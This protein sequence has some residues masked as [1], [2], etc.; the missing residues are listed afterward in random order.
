IKNIASKI[1]TKYHDGPAVF[2]NDG[3]T[4]YFTRTHFKEN[5]LSR[6]S[7]PDG[8]GTVHLQI[9]I[10]TGYNAETGSFDD[11][12]NFPYNSKDYSTA[13]PAISPSG[14]T[15]VFVSDMPGGKGGNDLY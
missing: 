4:M 7:V 8:N 12:S 15:I 6:G 9:K 11:I 10:A 14:K 1:N 13:H 5:F 2:S 3:T